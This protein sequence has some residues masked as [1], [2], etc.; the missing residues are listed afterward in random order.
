ME[1]YN[2]LIAFF[3]EYAKFFEDI[4][5]DEKK[6]LQALVNGEL[7]EIEHTISIQQANE[8]RIQNM[9]KKRMELQQSLGFSNQSFQQVIDSFAGEQQKHLH[10]LYARIG[11][12]LSEVKF[13]NQKG[14]DVATTNLHLFGDKKIQEGIYT[15]DAMKR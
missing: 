7:K 1:P 12:A 3:E 10:D 6:K 9:E 11:S 2:Q 5:G 8:K 14:M 13:Y 15:K 4:L